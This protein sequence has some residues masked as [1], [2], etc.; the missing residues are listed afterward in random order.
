MSKT[1]LAVV[2]LFYSSLVFGLRVG[3]AQKARFAPWLQILRQTLSA[4][5]QVEELAIQLL[6][7]RA[8]EAAFHVQALGK[9][10]QESDSDFEKLRKAAKRLEDAIGK[11]D[12]WT[13]ILK[14]AKNPTTSTRQK[15][16]AKIVDA[17]SA[18]VNLLVEEPWLPVS[19]GSRLAK[20]ESFIADYR[21][22]SYEED[23]DLM[24]KALGKLAKETEDTEFD[25]GILE[26]GNGLHELRRQLRWITIGS[27]ALNGLIVFKK[28]PRDC[29]IPFYKRLLDNK[30]LSESKYAQLPPSPTE[31]KPCEISK[32]LYL[33]LTD[34]IARLGDLK[35]SV[36]RES[37]GESDEVP[38]LVRRSAAVIYDELTEN[39]L[40]HT[41][42]KE[43][44]NCRQ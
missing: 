19:S 24:L 17:K 20:M 30:A 21:W 25:M 29:P 12:K 2:I 37:L 11:Y 4:T 16:E 5:P 7:N 6:T 35:D 42:A 40:L 44:K 18:L 9:L 41:L 36:E 8:R 14:Y 33:A 34:Y 22:A 23:R 38:S 27:K 31:T 39:R 32:C 28:N 13:S 15:L 26:E 3:D 1:L 43:L 10:Y